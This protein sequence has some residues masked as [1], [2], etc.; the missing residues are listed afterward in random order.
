MCENWIPGTQLPA[1][2]GTETFSLFRQMI[3]AAGGLSLSQVCA[4]TGL[5]GSTIQNW[6]KRDWVSKPVGK[7][8]GER[9]VARILI[10][11][12]LRDSLQLEQIAGLLQYVNGSAADQSDDIVAEGRLFNYFSSCIAALQVKDGVSR[13]KVLET[14]R[15]VLSDYTGPHPQAKEQLVNAL[16]VMVEAYLAASIRREAEWMLREL[17]G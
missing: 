3:E 11:N 10:I 15:R 2:D 6:V 14:V 9:Q 5:E 4:L 7:K 12:A 17:I 8:Y 16:C 1:A 13:E